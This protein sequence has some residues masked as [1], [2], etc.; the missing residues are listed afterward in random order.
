ML[1]VVSILAGAAPETLARTDSPNP[2]GPDDG[3]T[4][5]V[6]GDSISAA[7]GIQREQG[8]V[9][10]LRDR[11]HERGGRWQVVNASVSGETTGGGLAR[12]PDALAEHAPEVVILELGGNDGLRGYPVPRMRDNLTRM[13]RLTRDAGAVPLLVGMQIPPNYGPRY[14]RAFAEAYQEIASAED[15]ALVPFIL[16]RVA[17][18]PGLM[19]DDGIHPKAEAQVMLLDTVWPHLAP[20][21][22]LQTASVDGPAAG[23]AAGA[24]TTR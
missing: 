1:A 12:L 2:A 7:Y 3:A 24:A 4:I 5:L 6:F 10:Q 18:E 19:Q 13:V 14:T 23:H 22:D 17:L 16:E 8:W 11:L 21:L 9:E 20:L 15:V